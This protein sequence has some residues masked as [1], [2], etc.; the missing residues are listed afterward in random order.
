MIRLE[1]N[2]VDKVLIGEYLK[3]IER[4]VKNI[5]GL[6]DINSYRK[7]FEREFAENIGTKYA[8]A[9]N[10]GTD[11]LQL[12]LLS[13][14]IG[15]TDS[16]IL[17]DL[18]YVSTGLVVKYVEA[19]PI[20]VDVKKEDLTIDENELEK[21]IKNNTKAI[22][23]VHMFGRPCNMNKIINIAQKYKLYL[24][25]DACQALGSK[26][27]GK[28]VGLFGDIAAFSFSYY[29]PLSSLGGN[30][31]ILIFNKNEYNEKIYGYLNLWKK[32]LKLLDLG[33]KFNKISLTDIATAKIKLKYINR[34]IKSREDAKK[35]YEDNLSSIKYI[36]IFKDSKEIFSVRE[37]Y[38]ILTKDRDKL[39]IFLKRR[40]IE[41]E[42]PYPPLHSLGLFSRNNSDSEFKTSEEYFSKGLHLPLYTFM[43]KEEVLEVTKAIKDF[44]I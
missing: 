19:E 40:G 41:S 38:H 39:H 15:K 34:I 3:E 30:G 7:E 26:Y 28:S 12:A 16:V 9:V 24:I 23:A 31:G 36:N 18:T 20:F 1:N 17:P 32:D 22:I 43:K 13:L 8:L 21:K 5:G 14:G 6:D 44:Y 29:K 25:E 11:A 4:I 2:K 37:N 35:V 42:L 33:R 27:H 10:S